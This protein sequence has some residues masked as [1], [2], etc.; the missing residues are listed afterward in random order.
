MGEAARRAYRPARTEA[1]VARRFRAPLG[2]C[3]ELDV[4]PVTGRSHQIRA[5]LAWAGLPIVGDPKYGV[6]ARGIHRPLLH[7]ARVSFTHPRTRERVVIEAPIP[8]DEARLLRL[9]T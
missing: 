8:W 7:A 4:R 6:P 3:A 1:T 2:A 9:A 5:H